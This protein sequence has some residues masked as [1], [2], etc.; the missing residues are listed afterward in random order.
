MWYINK[1]EYVVHLHTYKHTHIHT[2]EFSKHV[3]KKMKLEKNH[4]SEE[5]QTQKDIHAY[6][7]LFGY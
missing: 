7:C 2:K 6:I 1:K 3:G 4:L 5:M